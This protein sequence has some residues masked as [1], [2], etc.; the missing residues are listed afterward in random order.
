MVSEV[1]KSLIRPGRFVK[2]GVRKQGLRIGEYMKRTF[3]GILFLCGMLALTGCGGHEIGMAT[4]GPEVT[5]GASNTGGETSSADITINELMA[6]NDNL[7][8]RTDEDWIELRNS[9][10][11]E[12]SL[13]GFTLSD[14]LDLAES[15][16]AL[17]GMTIPANGYLAVCLGEDAGFH[18]STDGETVYLLQNREMIDSMTYTNEI[19]SS[20]W[21]K[22]GVLSVATPG[23]E[24][25]DE[26]YQAYLSA[27]G[28]CPLVITEVLPY[29]TKYAETDGKYY[30]FVELYN[31]SSE[32]VN[33]STYYLSDDKD[34]LTKS[35]LPNETL[36]AGEYKIIYCS[37]LTDAGHACFKISSSG[38]TVYLSDASGLWDEIEIPEDLE[39]N[40]SYGRFDGK[41]VYMEQVTPGKENASG[42]ASRVAVPTADTASGL[43]DSAVNVTLTGE[44][45]IYYTTDGS[46]P[47]TSSNVYSGPITVSDVTTIRAYCVN[48]ERESDEAEFTYLID[49][50]HALPILTVSI[51]DS[52][53]NGKDGIFTNN[54]ETIEKE[55]VLTYFIDGVE[56]FSVPC[57]FRLHGNDSRKLAKQNFQLRFRSK[58]GPSKLHYKM[59]DDLDID[60]FDSLL[61]KGGSEDYDRAM[62]I[63]E[64][65]CDI[66]R[67]KTDL[68][69]LD[70]TP[71]VLYIGGEYWGIYYI[72]ERFS[73][74][75]VSS[76]FD[77]SDD[78]V[79]IL[80]GSGSIQS[81]SADD[82]NEV[83]SYVKNHDMSEASNYEYIESKVDVTS[84]MDW[85]ICRSYMGDKD[86]ANVRF[87]RSSEYDGKWRWMWF[88]LDWAFVH[89]TDEPLSGII[90]DNSQHTLIRAL[91]KNATFRDAFLKRYAEL[92]NT[93]LNEEYITSR[94]DYF[95]SILEP[96]M[97]QDRARWGGSVEKW[98]NTYVENLYAYVRD[99]KRDANVLKD[100]KSYFNLSDSEMKSYFGDKYQN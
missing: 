35:Q 68:Y 60:S 78:S 55:C 59:F 34:N 16:V 61:L 95:V 66:V 64:L 77:V 91:M 43:Y 20:S 14:N 71:C 75:F 29:N 22:D 88:D 72:R 12:V 99:G 21:G 23:Y 69:A 98:K 28:T 1:Y 79:D 10:D 15:S 39:D 100:L 41:L 32:A 56:Q 58:Y 89:T 46:H 9:E 4:N 84:L 25:S 47:S 40:K 62:M 52:S 97:E 38:E 94:I 50:N 3:A 42:Y 86:L 48:G 57:G 49:V 8:M 96:E 80:Y 90:K 76:H 24:N 37:G 19:G 63:D 27:T 18:L 44:G 81:G 11:K 5:G 13:D 54:L 31:S 82:W 33:L 87:F 2:H 67:G 30:D 7:L 45:T 6:S 53:L 93:I 73:Q 92:M 17:D 74:D 26:G 36:G 83:I 70:M 51:P 65:C 85:Y